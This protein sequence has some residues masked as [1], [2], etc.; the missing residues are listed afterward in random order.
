MSSEVGVD[1]PLIILNFVRRTL[2]QHFAMRQAVY[3]LGQIHDHAHVVLDYE[4]G[5]AKLGIGTL[6]PIDQPID[7]GWIDARG[8]FVE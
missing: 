1:Y 6:E 4:Q 8:G 2:G 5:N 3:G 7:Q